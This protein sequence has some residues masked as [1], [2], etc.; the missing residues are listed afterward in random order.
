MAETGDIRFEVDVAKGH[1]DYEYHHFPTFAAASDFAVSG[2]P[3]DFFGICAI[4]RQTCTSG[5]YGWWEHDR[6]WEVESGALPP[7][8]D[9][10]DRI[11][12]Y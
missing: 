12:V 4:R 6:H 10:P 2:A 3:T 9:E 1:D 11:E 7:V 5:K 8:E